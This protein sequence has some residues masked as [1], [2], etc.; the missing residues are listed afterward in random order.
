MNDQI[1]SF[2][3]LSL[4]YIAIRLLALWLIVEGFV[5]LATVLPYGGFDSDAAPIL[6]SV[7]PLVIGGLLWFLTP[8]ISHLLLPATERRLEV[9]VDSGSMVRTAVVVFGL[10][11][12][13][14]AIPNLVYFVIWIA[15][16]Q[17]RPSLFGGSS[18][19]E[20]LQRAMTAGPWSGQ[21]ARELVRLALG[22]LLIVG[23][24]GFTRLIERLRDF[25]LANKRPPE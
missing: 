8:M 9:L 6:V 22:L 13:V 17:E 23:S 20:Q 18:M 7:V 2:N 21:L 10:Y 4:A 24:G 14:S 11:L 5:Y 19:T 1:R 16:D 25:G 15:Q 3:G 12:V